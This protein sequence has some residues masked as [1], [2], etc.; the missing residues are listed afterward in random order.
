MKMARAIPLLSGG[1]AA[2]LVMMAAAPAL[3]S[4]G[5]SGHSRSGGHTRITSIL[6]AG[7]TTTGVRGSGG[8]G[9]VLTGSMTTSSGSQAAFLFRGRLAAAAGATGLGAAAAFPPGHLVHLLRPEYAPGQPPGDPARGRPGSGQLRL[10]GRT[11]GRARPGHDL[12]RAAQRAG[13]L[14]EVHRRARVWQA[15]HRARPGLPAVP[16]QVRGHG[17]H[18]AQHHG[19]PGGGQLRPE[20]D[21]CAAASSRATRSST[22][23]PSASGPCSGC[24]GSLSTKTSLYGIWQDGGPGARA[25]RWPAVL[26]PRSPAR[27]PDQL[28]RADRRLRPGHRYATTPC[29]RRSPTSRGSP[30]SRAGSTSWRISPAIPRRWSSS[31]SGARILRPGPLAP[32]QR[33]RESALCPC[34]A[35]TGNTVWRNRIMGLYVPK[36][37]SATHSYLK[38]PSRRGRR[39]AW[40]A[41]GKGNRGRPRHTP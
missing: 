12:P 19:Q 7:D 18:R 21:A 37:S 34:S 33:W 20:P 14:L 27:I 32:G 25:T 30:L 35:V 9:V 3:A 15:R 11:L 41:P 31:R 8:S 40:P 5:R 1:T 26:S 24:D 13:R 22:T 2:M 16:A 6:K 28:Q 36:S 10:V 29:P 17:H 39:A 23:S 4:P 38:P